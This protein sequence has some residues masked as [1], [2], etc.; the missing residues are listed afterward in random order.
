MLVN[1][2]SC[3]LEFF[4]AEHKYYRVIIEVIMLLFSIQHCKKL[5]RKISQL[6]TGDILH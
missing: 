2:I 6:I 5:I 4:P 3:T 1:L